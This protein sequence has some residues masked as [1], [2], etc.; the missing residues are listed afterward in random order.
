[1]KYVR[2]W[3]QKPRRYKEQEDERRVTFLELFYDL[4]FV[5]IIAEL[6]HSLSMDISW[7]S[8][9]KFSFLFLII[10]WAWYNGALYHD[11]HGNNDIK[12]RIMTFLQMF[13][14]AAMAVFAH[15]AIGDTS[16]GFALSY[17]FFLLIITYLWWRTGVHDKEHR[18]LSYPFSST[19]LIITALILASVFVDPPYRYYMWAVG[20]FI[21]VVSPLVLLVLG[22]SNSKM[23]VQINQASMVSSSMTERFGL[24]TIIVLG[25][26]IVGVVQGLAGHHHLNLQLGITAG[27]GMLV[28]IGIWWIYFDLISYFVP[29]KNLYWQSIWL[30]MHLPLTISIAAVGAAI[31]NLIGHSGDEVPENAKYLLSAAVSVSYISV[32]FIS[33]TI[34]IQEEHKRV[35]ST[36]R[37]S[38]FIAAGATLLLL[39]FDLSVNLFLGLTLAVMMTPI[40]LAIKVW[41]KG[42]IKNTKTTI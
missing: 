1:M 15:H 17:G 36:G 18:I 6:A 29:K 16:I 41:I 27:L 9:L 10:W 19:Y 37:I 22:R 30:Y 12:T 33:M 7:I 13:G 20:L 40:F 42:Q 35:N 2:I 23:M 26:V 14:I 5:V 25:E 3:W 4:V 31:L 32:G 24:L 8:I 39:L 11:V 21:K 28:A 34:Q 38:V